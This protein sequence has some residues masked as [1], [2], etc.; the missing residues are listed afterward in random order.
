MGYQLGEMFAECCSGRGGGGR[1][2]CPNV[3]GGGCIGRC[4]GM[5]V[6]DRGC[7]TGDPCRGSEW[8]PWVKCVLCGVVDRGGVLERARW[9]VPPIGAVKS[10]GSAGEGG[11]SGIKSAWSHWS[12]LGCLFAAEVMVAVVDGAGVDCGGVDGCGDVVAWEAVFG[13]AKAG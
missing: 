10:E 2:G 12:G 11:F 3:V 5:D 7:G 8:R 6:V 9:G 4:V 13:V 1:F